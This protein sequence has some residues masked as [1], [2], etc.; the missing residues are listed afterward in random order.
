MKNKAFVIG[1]FQPFH[2]GHAFLIQSALKLG[3]EVT[4]LV[5]SANVARSIKNPLTFEER[6][7]II[8]SEFPNVTVIPICD[9]PYDDRLWVSQIKEII[10]DCKNSCIVGS[11]KD[12]STY[13]LKIFGD[14]IEVVDCP[15]YTDEKGHTINATMVRE[16]IFEGKNTSLHWAF[17]SKSYDITMRF[18]KTTA[19]HLFEE[20]AY[21]KRY[22]QAWSK[23][24]FPPIFVT[25][26]SVVVHR[27]SFL[28]VIRKGM[29]GK[30]LY[31]MPGGFIE[32]GEFIKESALRELR[33]ET[34]FTVRNPNSGAKLPMM[35]EWLKSSKVFDHPNRSTRGRT[36]THAFAWMIPDKYEIDV[37]AADDAAG[38][39]WLPISMLTDAMNA[40]LFMEDH[41][42]IAKDCISFCK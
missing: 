7:E 30:G 12:E 28:A 35:E 37:T 6:A 22:K 25:V 32:S 21:I 33:E 41:F 13:Y 36:I 18:F 29:P 39:A 19:N 11:N 5:G 26:D 9:Y 34:L 10:S 27:S 8:K 14:D 17:S 20:W 16:A 38:V 23:S 3:K 42:H 1:R 31:A 40:K 2:I 24:P 15:Q 4:I